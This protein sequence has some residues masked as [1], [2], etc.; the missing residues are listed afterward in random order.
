MG[1][2]TIL[3]FSTIP[4]I[5]DKFLIPALIVFIALLL[6]FGGRIPKEKVCSKCGGWAM[7]C[8]GGD[9]EASGYHCFSCKKCSRCDRYK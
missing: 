3:S 2:S 6:Y 4:G 9:G 7:L 1:I 8:E 5:P